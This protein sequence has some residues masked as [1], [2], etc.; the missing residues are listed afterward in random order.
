MYAR[1]NL[2]MKGHLKYYQEDESN[3]PS[4]VSPY[5]CAVTLN[6]SIICELLYGLKNVFT[7]I[8][9]FTFTELCEG[10]IF[11]LQIKKLM[12]Q[13]LKKQNKTKIMASGSIISWQTEKEKVEVVT[14]F[15]FLGSNITADGV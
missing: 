10:D 8:L 11:L 9:S 4:I 3:Y 13:W 1:E 2:N 6:L 12:S 5:S 14:D 15:I 7:H